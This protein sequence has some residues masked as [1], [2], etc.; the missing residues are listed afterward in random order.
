MYPKDG[1]RQPVA[2]L[3]ARSETVPETVVMH[4]GSGSYPKD[5]YWWDDAAAEWVR[6][7][8]G[9]TRISPS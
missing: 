5:P 1:L 7:G 8:D 6:V 3:Q 4:D 2:D 9:S